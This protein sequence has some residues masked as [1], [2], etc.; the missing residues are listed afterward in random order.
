MSERFVKEIDHDI[1]NA[2]PEMLR[3]ETTPR[4]WLVINALLDER[5]EVSAAHEQAQAD[6]V[7]L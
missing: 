1:I 6:F 4:V 3:R 7:L 2:T 5:N